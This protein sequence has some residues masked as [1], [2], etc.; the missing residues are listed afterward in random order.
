MR[1]QYSVSEAEWEVLQMLWQLG[2]EA[3]QPKILEA[4]QNSGK[5][6][7]RQTVNTFLARLEE[8]GLVKREKRIV[9]AVYSEEEYK[10]RQM[11]LAIETMY[12]GK[13][14]NFMAAFQKKHAISR[15]DAEELKELL[16]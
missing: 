1:N 2:G 8:K 3:R 16:K 10:F 6:W 14:S 4:L 9:S 13:L 12:D 5:E 11:E 7:K 15:E